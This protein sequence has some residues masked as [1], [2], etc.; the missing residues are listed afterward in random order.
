MAQR[1]IIL[2]LLAVAALGSAWLMN[3]M[4]VQGGGGEADTSRDPDYYMEDFN[5]LS[6]R[7]DGT[8]KH[9]LEAVYMA[10][11]PDNDATELLQPK[12][13]IFR[14][15]KTPLFVTA[16]KGWVTS[17][18]EVILLK[19]QVRLWENN[20]AG[21]RTLEVDT[22]EV[23]VLRDEEYAETDEYATI[24]SGRATIT[25]TAALGLSTDKDQPIQV[26]ADTAELDDK[27][28]VS[29]Y[30][31]DVVLTQGSIRMTGDK[32][33]VYNTEDDELDTLIMEGSPATYR[34]LPDDS[35]VYDEA[36]AKTIKY[37]ELKHQV[38]L[39][40][41]AVVRQEGFLMKGDRID[42]DTERNQA[43]AQSA[44]AGEGAEKQDRVKVI[45]KKKEEENGDT[46]A[47]PDG[48]P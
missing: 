9:R 45:L 47:K 36:E 20:A 19:G 29:V 33:T 7:E 41:N 39:I 40:D 46:P 16:E 26:E 11:Y 15:D 34:Q 14:R 10:H 27:N 13:E 25:G 32:M 23:R 43:K 21:E 31:G 24:K 35:D 6:M 30:T 42:Y 5:T 2:A 28:N 17:G 8:P 48:Q 18:N 12:M 4:G 37:F 38:I 22:S 3:R 1:I 44:A